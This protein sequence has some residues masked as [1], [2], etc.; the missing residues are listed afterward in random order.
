M[1]K[2]IAI[3]VVF[4][5]AAGA[6]FAQAE[7]S[8]GGAVRATLFDIHSESDDVNAGMESWFWISAG[9]TNDEGTMGAKGGLSINTQ[10]GAVNISGDDTWF[11]AWWQPIEYIFVKMGKVGEDGKYWAG[12]GIG[13]WDF[14]SNDL[15]I[16]PAF[17]YYNGFA[18]G[19]MGDGHGYLDNGLGT[20]HGL[21]F[22]LTNIADILTINFGLAFGEDPWPYGNASNFQLWNDASE[23]SP[24]LDTLAV[25]AVV[26]IPDVGQLAVGF[27]NAAE[28]DPINMYL[29]YKMGLTDDMKIEVGANLGFDNDSNLE[30]L[31]AGIGF[32]YG[33]PWGDDFWLTARIGLQF[34]MADGDDHAIVGLGITPSY[35][36]GI[37]RVYVPIDI[38]ISQPAGGGDALFAWGFNPYI[39]KQM[40]GLEMWTGFYVYNGAQWGLTEANAEEVT[41]AYQLGFLWAW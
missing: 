15:F 32:G 41:F 33:S 36:L 13:A 21:Q 14:Q 28:G 16:S 37:F 34:G 23:S 40:G 38:A 7:F 12:A 25:Q 5:L 30:P 22:S 8:A 20:T 26:E 3:L 24:I 39:R 2:L 6:A 18:S 19:V 35:D 29:Q 31:K 17:D 1:R 11:Y 9:K 27:K 10:G 4:A